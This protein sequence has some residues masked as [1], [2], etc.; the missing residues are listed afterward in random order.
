[1]KLVHVVAAALLGYI[2][3]RAYDRLV[4]QPA[5]ERDV[6]T[7]LSLMPELHAVAKKVVAI[8]PPNQ[9]MNARAV[10]RYIDRFARLYYR[11]TGKA[12]MSPC[13]RSKVLGDVS[14]VRSQ[15]VNALQALYVS[16]RRNTHRAL[17]DE[18]TAELMHH[19][20]IAIRSVRRLIGKPNGYTAGRGFP[21]GLASDFDPM[22]DK[23][24]G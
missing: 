19:T 15:A 24:V 8:A 5:V 16:S 9:D 10:A 3:L 14:M 11:V 6:P 20:D 12:D 13:E 2:G 1:M 22:Y 17:L 18:C 4:T 7:A 23:V 21:V